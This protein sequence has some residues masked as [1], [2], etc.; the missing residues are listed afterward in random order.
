MVGRWPNGDPLVPQADDA[1]G[2][3]DFMY[4]ADDYEGLH[5]PVGSHLRRSNPRD[6]FY[7]ETLESSLTIVDKHRII[8]RGRIY[9][10]P[11]FPIEKLDDPDDTLVDI[12]KTSRMMNLA[13]YN[14]CV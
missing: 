2:K 14:S 8:R 4:A 7:S 12:L 11:A 6:V 10:D 1:R 13:V 5:C 3:D 9:G